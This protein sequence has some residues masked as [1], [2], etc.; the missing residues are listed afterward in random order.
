MITKMIASPH[1]PR[2]RACISGKETQCVLLRVCE[3]VEG[4]DEIVLDNLITILYTFGLV[5]VEGNVYKR[6]AWASIVRVL[7]I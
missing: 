5:L 4:S 1:G 6:S 7:N 2:G 3:S